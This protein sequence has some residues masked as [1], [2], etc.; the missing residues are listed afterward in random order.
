M[1]KRLCKS[2]AAAL[3]AVAL[4]FGSVDVTAEWAPIIDTDPT[5][6]A[7]NPGRPASQNPTTV[8]AFLQDLLNLT[9]APTLRRQHSGSSGAL[10]GIGDPVTGLFLLAYHYGNDNGG[11]E[12]DGPF[13]KFFSCQS[14]CDSVP[15]LDK[16]G[17]GNY[18]PLCDR[19]PDTD[20]EPDDYFLY[21]ADPDTDAQPDALCCG[22]VNPDLPVPEPASIALLG[23]GLA[24]LAIRRRKQ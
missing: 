11:W 23:L 3:W 6:V 8:G 15:L 16:N 9:T 17:L 2:Y 10:S 20:A 5:D 14:G 19:P 18:F 12:H 13:D 4:A 21:A 7:T 1:P 22:I 24:A